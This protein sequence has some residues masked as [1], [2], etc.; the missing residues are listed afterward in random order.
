MGVLIEI[1]TC[2][3]TVIVGGVAH[4]PEPKVYRLILLLARRP[5]IIRTHG[6][7]LDAM[8]SP[9]SGPDAVTTA[10]K[11]A[12]RVVGAQSIR[13]RTGLGYIWGSTPTRIIE[14][15]SDAGR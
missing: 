2:R 14:G 5:Q 9:F 1:D 7:I 10:V 13:V 3:A 12:R 11:K 6:Q 4:E 8:G 15:E